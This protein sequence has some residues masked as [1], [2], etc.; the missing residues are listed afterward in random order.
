MRASRAACSLVAHAEAEHA[1]TPRA[2]ARASRLCRHA[3]CGRPPPPPLQS[4]PPHRKTLPPRAGPPSP[5]PPGGP[6][7]PPPPRQPLPARP[8][9]GTPPSLRTC[10]TKWRS[11]CA[12]AARRRRAR[13]PSRCPPPGPQLAPPAARRRRR[14]LRGPVAWTGPAQASRHLGRLL[15]GGRAARAPFDVPRTPPPHACP[16][17]SPSPPPRPGRPPGL[18][19]LHRDL[20]RQQRD[21]GVTRVV[22]RDARRARDVRGRL[23]SPVPG[24]RRR[25]RPKRARRRQRGAGARGGAPDPLWR[26][27]AGHRR[28]SEHAKPPSMTPRARCAAP[29]RCPRPLQVLP[30]A[31]FVDSSPS[32]GY[33]SPELLVKR[34]SNPQ[35]GRPIYSLR[36]GRPLSACCWLDLGSAALSSL[37]AGCLPTCLPTCLPG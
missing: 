4:L 6:S 26:A 35:V 19:S 13:S 23:R 5:P 11:R 37:G 20:G 32:N 21:R 34:W 27:A 25:G 17:V 36:S 15:C 24:H 22:P 7:F 16:P 3:G 1:A 9:P 8:T 28:S 18:P 33:I 30:S 12:P 14:R 10:G 2:D 31:P 29:P